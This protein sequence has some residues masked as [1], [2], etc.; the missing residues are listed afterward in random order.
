MCLQSTAVPNQ[1][2]W[3]WTDYSIEQVLDGITEQL[4][5]FKT[6]SKPNWYHGLA[7]PN[8]DEQVY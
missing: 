4:Q 7:F 2:F 6:A 1:A 8:V 5:T 3:F